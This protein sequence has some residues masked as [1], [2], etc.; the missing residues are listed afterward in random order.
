MNR[1]VEHHPASRSRASL[2][3]RVGLGLMLV[4]LCYL[5]AAWLT[6]FLAQ[7]AC[8]DAGGRLETGDICILPDMATRSALSLLR[9]PLIG[10]IFGMAALAGVFAWFSICRRWPGGRA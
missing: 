2:P 10:A 5:C 9:G 1:H 7:D 4:V 6:I 8:L 3:V